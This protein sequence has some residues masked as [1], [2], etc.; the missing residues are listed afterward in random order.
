MEGPG[1][2]VGM[3]TIRSVAVRV[4]AVSAVLASAVAGT[5]PARALVA[6]NSEHSTREHNVSSRGR[7]VQAGPEL[8]PAGHAWTVTLITGDIVQ[9]KTV[10][11]RPP[12]VSV[13]PAAGHKGVIFTKF[14]DSRG[15]IEVLPSSV[16]PLIGRVLD[17]AL[18]NVTTL[19][20]N[21]DDD[22]QRAALP[23][24]IQGHPD[25]LSA[26][27]S[28]ARGPVLTSIGAVGAA[29]P[30]RTAAKVAGRW[31]RWRGPW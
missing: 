25:G 8:L 3:Q 26:L 13:T 17:P 21:A 6:M 22:A 15:D 20:Q 31:P 28:L 23:L 11:G 9:V 24:I 12:L 16:V 4:A 29:E 30:R 1:R 10:R 5:G 14:V 18:F 27:P 7:S 19:I 2:L